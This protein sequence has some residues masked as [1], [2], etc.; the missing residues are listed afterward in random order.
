MAKE[1]GQIHSINQQFAIPVGLPWVATVAGEIDIPFELSEQL[2]RTVRQGNFF[3]IVGIDMTLSEIGGSGGG[4][5][6]NGFLRYYAPT[7][8]RCSAYRDAFKAM[9]DVM[10][11][12]GINTRDNPLYDFRVGF[13]EG[14][15]GFRNQATLDGTNGLCFYKPS[16][17]KQSVFEVHNEGVQ[18]TYTGSASDLFE[19]GFDTIIQSG[20]VT[21]DFVLN[22]AVMY[23]G[24]HETAATEWETIPFQL[25]YAPGSDDVSFTLQWRPDPALYLAVMGGLFQVYIDE[26]STNGSATQLKLDVKV[27]CSGWKSIMGNPDKKSNRKGGR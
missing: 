24:N 26:A 10:K 4:G 8:G 16:A 1:L 3:K 17:P 22:D 15:A 18:P 7:K 19:T 27:M 13:N 11:L 21:T 9:R 12:Q 2:S 20:L 6:V 5:S 25:S 23:T 14:S